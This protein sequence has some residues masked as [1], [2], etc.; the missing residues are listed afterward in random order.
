VFLSFSPDQRHRHRHPPHYHHRNLDSQDSR[1]H[2]NTALSI[3]DPVEMG[4]KRLR[5][6]LEKMA[7]E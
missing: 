7:L 3:D 5:T 1:R 4:E 6:S 2:S